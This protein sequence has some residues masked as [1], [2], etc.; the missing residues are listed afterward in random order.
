MK[1]LFSNTGRNVRLVRLQRVVQQ[2]FVNPNQDPPGSRYRPNNP[3][4]ETYQSEFNHKL[5]SN[6]HLEKV[7]VGTYWLENPP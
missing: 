6:N 1:E 7:K 3:Q 4:N 5:E 2:F